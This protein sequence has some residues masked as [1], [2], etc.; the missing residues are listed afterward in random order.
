MSLTTLMLLDLAVISLFIMCRTSALLFKFVE[1]AKARLFL[2]RPK[3]AIYFTNGE[4]QTNF[5]GLQKKGPPWAEPLIT[6]CQVTL[7]AGLTG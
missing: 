1:L 4:L 2:T 6:G 5:S 7:S 3:G